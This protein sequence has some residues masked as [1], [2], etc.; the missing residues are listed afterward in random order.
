MFRVVFNFVV[1]LQAEN[2]MTLEELMAK[3][4]S[5]PQPSKMEVDSDDDCKYYLSRDYRFLMENFLDLYFQSGGFSS[6]NVF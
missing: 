6:L 4:K 3:Y 1:Y 2:N 5:A